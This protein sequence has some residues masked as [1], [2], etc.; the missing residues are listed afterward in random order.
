MS[1]GAMMCALHELIHDE[2]DAPMHDE[3]PA[4]MRIG[5]AIRKRTCV[6]ISAMKGIGTASP[7]ASPCSADNS[8]NGSHAT[9][10]HYD[11]PPLQQLQRISRQMRSP[12]HLK[13]RAAEYQREIG[14]ATRALAR[15]RSTARYCTAIATLKRSSGLIR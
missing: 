1:S 12:E 10:S 14:L 8:S 15:S 11:Y 3:S 13:Q 4:A 9:L 6:S 2:A 7:S 5:S